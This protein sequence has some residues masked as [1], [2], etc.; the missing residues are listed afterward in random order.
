MANDKLTV[1]GGSSANLALT[2]Q[3]QAKQAQAWLK[4]NQANLAAAGIDGGELHQELIR[5]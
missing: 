5:T 1:T 2:P 3:E 4:A